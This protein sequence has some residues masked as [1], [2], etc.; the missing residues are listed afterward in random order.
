MA[1]FL[2]IYLHALVGNTVKQRSK[3]AGREWRKGEV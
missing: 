2:F 1:P 3:E